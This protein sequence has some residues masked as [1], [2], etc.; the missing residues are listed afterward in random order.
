MAVTAEKTAIVD[1]LKGKLTS[2]K[3]AVFVGFTG[4]TV[5]DVTKL[6]R[7]FLAANVEYN[8]VKNTLTRIAAQEAGLEG[9]AEFLE[10][11]TALAFSAEDPVAP[12]KV[13]KEFIK[14]TKTEALQ[15][16]VGVVEGKVID[17]A[18]VDEL[19]SLPSREEL[20]AKLLGSMQAPISG[21][22]NVLQGTI[23]NMVY[24]L[25]AIREQKEQQASA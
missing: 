17:A 11:P 6:R 12:A 8:V 19:A 23:R 25:D 21:T 13:L 14:E 9:V 3:G 22:V 5:A 7:K 1:S 24:V 20:I 2:A 10:G 16:K 18:G 15:I 4:L